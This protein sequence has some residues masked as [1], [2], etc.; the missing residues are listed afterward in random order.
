MSFFKMFQGSASYPHTDNFLD[1]AFV[2]GEPIY[3]VQGQCSSNS[4]FSVSFKQSSIEL[5]QGIHLL[6]FQFFNK[7]LVS[8]Q[9]NYKVDF[10]FL[11][12]GH[13]MGE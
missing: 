9:N 6:H 2:S 5:Q 8:L 12:N 13:E 1:P 10:N 3:N 7:I 4:S 11:L